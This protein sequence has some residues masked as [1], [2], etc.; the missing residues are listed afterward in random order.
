MQVQIGQICPGKTCSAHHYLRSCFATDVDH[1][2]A[3]G[4]MGAVPTEQLH[5]GGHLANFA[6][7]TPSLLH[8]SKRRLS[9]FPGFS[10]R[11]CFEV[12]PSRQNVWFPF[13]P[14]GCPMVRRVSKISTSAA[15]SPRS[16]RSRHPSVSGRAAPAPCFLS[17]LNAVKF[18]PFSLLHSWLLNGEL[19]HSSLSMRSIN[20]RSFQ[21]RSAPSIGIV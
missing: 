12:H 19:R 21:E 18:I 16:S 6:S 10:F 5:R 8:L 7:G 2:Q 9:P 4:S 13:A 17:L 11:F 3:S 20:R 14:V 1:H 15:G